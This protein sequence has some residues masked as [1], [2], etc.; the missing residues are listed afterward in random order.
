MSLEFDVFCLFSPFMD[1]ATCQSFG[2]MAEAK[3]MSK[4]QAIRRENMQIANFC[5][6]SKT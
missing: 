4:L 5:N 1:T 2:P 3:K 6:G